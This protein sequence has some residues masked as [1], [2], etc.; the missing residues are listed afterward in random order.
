MS[1]ILDIIL[2]LIIAEM[3]VHLN[4]KEKKKFTKEILQ[5]T[6]HL[7]VDLNMK[8]S[9]DELWL[10]MTKKKKNNSFTV[11]FKVSLLFI[12]IYR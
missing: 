11:H 12:F 7:L 1:T 9:Q 10:D 2:Q 4:K 3:F 6:S 8:K 5:N